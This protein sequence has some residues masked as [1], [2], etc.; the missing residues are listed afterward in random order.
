MATCL[1]AHAIP[2]E[3]ESADAYITLCIDHLFPDMVE[4]D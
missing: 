1:A 4:W 2:A 3:A